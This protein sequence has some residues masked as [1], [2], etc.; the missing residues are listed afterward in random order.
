MGDATPPPADPALLAAANRAL[1]ADLET[2]WAERDE[3]RAAA[4]EAVADPRDVAAGVSAREVD[5]GPCPGCG[6]PLGWSVSAPV[7]STG[8]IRCARDCGHRGRHLVRRADGEVVALPDG[9]ETHTARLARL[10]REARNEAHR[11]EQQRDAAIAER[12][13]LADWLLRIDGGDHPC[14]DAATLRRW[15]YEAVTLRREVDRG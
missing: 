15:A 12:D 11:L 9:A 5:G 6:G 7:G 14:D 3:A 4:I 1:V 13:R 8:R 2:A 10:A